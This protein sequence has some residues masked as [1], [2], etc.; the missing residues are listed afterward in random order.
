MSVL[1]FW[2]AGMQLGRK[3]LLGARCGS[4]N[5]PQTLPNVSPG[6]FMTRKVD[7]LGIAMHEIMH[8]STLLQVHLNTSIANNPFRSQH[9]ILN[10]H[11][12]FQLLVA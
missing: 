12:G 4:T 7:K 9:N 5:I 10:L 11:Q 3:L 2:I 6:V 1:V 8:H